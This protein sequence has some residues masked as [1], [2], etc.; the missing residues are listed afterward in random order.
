MKVHHEH[1]PEEEYQRHKT[2][3][4][5]EFLAVSGGSIGERAER[6]AQGKIVYDQEQSALGADFLVAE[7]S[8]KM[9][10]R[11]ENKCVH[12]HIIYA[13]CA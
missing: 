11:A 10:Q 5:G 7:G 2:T 9:L 6:Q 13:R 8:G 3:E 4:Q 12:V 1:E